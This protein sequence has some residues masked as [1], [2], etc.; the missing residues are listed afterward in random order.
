[1]EMT[2]EQEE[3][4]E[5]ERQR[6][7]AFFKTPTYESFEICY[8]KNVNEAEVLV[9]KEHNI[10]DYIALGFACL[11]KQLK[12][13]SR[14]INVGYAQYDSP[15]LV[16]ILNTVKP[17]KYGGKRLPESAM[18]HVLDEISNITREYYTNP[19]YDIHIQITGAIFA[20]FITSIVM[21]YAKE[22]E[23]VLL[24]RNFEDNAYAQELAFE[25]LKK[26]I[27][28][29]TLGSLYEFYFGE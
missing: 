3:F 24:F 6:L 28:S 19:E 15:V 13:S 8:V 1:M 21:G 22:D 25:N 27:I 5:K 20:P 11:N 14:I 23:M 9:S 18:M 26:F 17:C 2:K 4:F 10:L 16:K 29:S 7:E 12:S